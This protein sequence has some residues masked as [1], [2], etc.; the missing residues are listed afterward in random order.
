[1][2]LIHIGPP[3]ATTAIVADK[4]THIESVT[5]GNKGQYGFVIGLVS[6]ETLTVWCDLETEALSMRWKLLQALA[7]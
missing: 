5:M 4:I 7:P 6:R 3:E 1:M 2:K